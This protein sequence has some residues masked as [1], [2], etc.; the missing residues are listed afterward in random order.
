MKFDRYVD[1]RLENWGLW[2]VKFVSNGL[3]YPSTSATFKLKEDGTAVF[4][5]SQDNV[6]VN[7]QAEEV[8]KCINALARVY[9]HCADAIKIRYTCRNEKEEIKR[10][11][12]SR[13]TYQN[14]LR[15]AKMWVASRL[16][17]C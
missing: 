10:R 12:I 4:E 6:L 1:L 3:G 9:P 8:D 15:M 16:G 11:N 5:S 14:N 17:L 7:P 2:R 13:G